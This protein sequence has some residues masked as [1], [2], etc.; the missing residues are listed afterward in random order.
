MDQSHGRLIGWTRATAGWAGRATGM[1]GIQALKLGATLITL[2]VLAFLG[3]GRK[4]A[5]LVKGDT[6]AI[7]SPMP[8]LGLN[9]PIPWPVFGKV[10][11]ISAF[12]GGLLVSALTR[13]FSH[14]E[15]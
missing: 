12:G 3:F 15:N 11:A 14:G 2:G 4:E 5:F 8:W 7:A 6:N 10:V 1:L 13:W 9:K